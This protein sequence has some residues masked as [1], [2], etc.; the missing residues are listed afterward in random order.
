MT[1]PFLPDSTNSANL[2]APAP[3]ISPKSVD[4]SPGNACV[5]A[6]VTNLYT[7]MQWFEGEPLTFICAALDL[8]NQNNSVLVGDNSDPDG[9]VVKPVD[10]AVAQEG[11]LSATH[12]F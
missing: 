3:G 12:P 8:R 7:W 9:I 5:P 11:G 1:T 4:H 10:V 6:T 2:P